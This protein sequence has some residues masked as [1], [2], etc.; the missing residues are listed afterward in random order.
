[1]APQFQSDPIRFPPGWF[2]SLKVVPSKIPAFAP[3]WTL[4]DRDLAERLHISDDTTYRFIGLVRD[5]SAGGF[6]RRWG[7]AR[8]RRRSEICAL[9]ALHFMSYY[10][11]SPT[12]H[13]LDRSRAD[14]A[15]SNGSQSSAPG[16][17]LASR[18]G[19]RGAHPLR[20]FAKAKFARYR[21]GR[22]T[23]DDIKAPAPQVS[24]DTPP[25]AASANPSRRRR[26]SS[27][28]AR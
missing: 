19:E 25:A 4:P 23:R 10:P 17:Q 16:S 24:F 21:L 5:G 18:K 8:R 12:G 6:R 9:A 20:A 1:M 11:T 15:T 3:K 27:G 7:Y 26:R 28:A 2:I 22:N 14:D 13:R